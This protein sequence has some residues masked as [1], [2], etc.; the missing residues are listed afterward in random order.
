[1]PRFAT[2]WF[3]LCPCLVAA[4]TPASLERAVNS[5]TADDIRRRIAILADDS[6]RGRETPSPELDK[7]ATWIAGEFRRFGLK[8]GAGDGTY[9]QRYVDSAETARPHANLPY[10]DARAGRNRSRLNAGR[11][12]NVLQLGLPQPSRDVTGPR[13]AIAQRR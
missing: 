8:P 2:F 11:D 12:I 7:V 1:M 3:L 5:I 4:Q 9:V 6:T 13:P 10:G